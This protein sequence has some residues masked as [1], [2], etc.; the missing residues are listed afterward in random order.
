[1]G[2]KRARYC[3]RV[4]GE[5]GYRIWD[6]LIGRWWGKP[7]KEFPSANIDRLNNKKKKS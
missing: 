3:V 4:D 2:V 5:R 7:S 6:R 1:M